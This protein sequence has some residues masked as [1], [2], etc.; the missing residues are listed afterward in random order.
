M[1]KDLENGLEKPLVDDSSD[2]SLP[3]NAGTEGF[4]PVAALG[5]Y[6][7][8][9]DAV[10][11]AVVRKVD[12]HIMPLIT[13]CYLF[14]LLDRHSIGLARIANSDDSHA[15]P[16]H[17][18][19]P[20]Q[21]SA[22]EEELGLN[23]SQYASVLFAFVLG[24]TLFEVPSNLLMKRATPSFWISR[25]MVS[26]GLV[27]SLT[28]FVWDF[29]SLVVARFALGVAEAGFFPGILLYFTFWY[30]RSEQALRLALFM[31]SSTF[32][33]A[34]G[35]VLAFFLSRMDGVMGLS[36]FRW[37]FL[38]EG[39]P[40]VALGFVVYSALP[41]FPD[42]APFLTKTEREVAVSRLGNTASSNE[43]HFDWVQFKLAI[44]DPVLHLFCIAYACLMAPVHSLSYFLPTI[45]R[46]FG[47]SSGV[48]LL[49]TAPPYIIAMCV[50]LPFAFHSDRT[51]ERAVHVMAAVGIQFL[52]Y[53]V[54]WTASS[55]WTR[56]LFG[57]LVAQPAASAAL[58]VY[59]SWVTS[60]FSIGSQTRAAVSTAAV[61]AFGN[62]L[63]GFFGANNF[64][65]EDAP[66][67]RAGFGRNLLF[68]LG[69]LVVILILRRWIPG[70][71]APA[72]AST[73]GSSKK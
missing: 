69:G 71:Y 57:C 35:G 24:Y 9:S 40:S 72:P 21:H 19:T 66:L 36:G 29:R 47:F 65:K 49:M 7:N 18:G 62:L 43:S 17:G 41:N 44:K 32:A 16:S 50:Q 42:S 54:L 14:N 34:F 31:V 64:K 56:Y 27:T 33:G 51:G 20:G 73:E 11:R 55:P 22:M 6:E 28:A 5:G 25:I 45:I 48:S 26:W 46:S 70:T 1:D 10:E 52:G 39:L 37:I 3:T 8:Y 61:V 23:E 63:G 68:N 2:N 30:R 53:F 60:H 13:V 38:A 58:V 15:G 12:S 59:L 67:Y 4:W